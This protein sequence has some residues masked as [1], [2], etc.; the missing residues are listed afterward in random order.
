MKFFKKLLAIMLALLCVCAI[1]ACDDETEELDTTKSG[2]A[3][4]WE[5]EETDDGNYIVV[6]G[7]FVSDA[8]K[9]S[10]AKDNYE[11]K[12]L[13]IG[14]DGKIEVPQYDENEKPLYNEDGTLKTE[15]IALG[16][17]YVAFKIADA[18]FA[19]QLIIGTVTIDASV[20][21]IGATAFAGCTNLTKMELPYVG[22]TATGAVNAKKIFAYIF[23]S[24]E[25]S[26]CTSVTCNYNS[27]GTGTYYLPTSLTEVVVNYAEGS[28]LPEYAF[29]GVTTLK[30][31]T[32]NGVNVVERNAF[33]GCIAL[34]TVV[35]PDSVTE[36]GKSAFNGCS[37]LINFDFPAELTTIFQEAFYGCVKIGYGKATVVELAKV[38]TIHDK[39]FYGCTS[40]S[41]LNLP[42]AKTIGAAAFYNCASLKSV[43]HNAT[44]VGNDA[45]SNCHDDLVIND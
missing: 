21:E 12:D 6:T 23:G 33:A 34:N 32:V 19:N 45:F 10:L 44:N 28:V 7:L 27:T 17:D 15:E 3:L 5:V 35:L 42:A 24:A 22:S 11:T 14:V 37:S 9:A 41:T 30:K 1:T 29:S 38:E 36:I 31:I 26:G 43:T 2:V 4:E 13:K 18:A 20:A 40:I 8:E 25:A 16:E 39:A